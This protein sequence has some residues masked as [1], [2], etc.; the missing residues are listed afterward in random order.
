[1]RIIDKRANAK[2]ITKIDG[3]IG[4]TLLNIINCETQRFHRIAIALKGERHSD[5]SAR[6][7]T[8]A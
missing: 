6:L 4:Q 3:L 8:G 1:M 7:H 2:A 5:S